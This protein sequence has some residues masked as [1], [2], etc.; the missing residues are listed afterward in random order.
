MSGDGTQPPLD[1]ATAASR[2]RQVAVLAEPKLK[3]RLPFYFPGKITGRTVYVNDTPRVYSLRD[4]D[5]N[6][7]RAYRIVASIGESG[8]FWGVQGLTWRTPWSGQL[9]V[10]ADNV[11]TRGKNPFSTANQ[12]DEGTVPYVRY[13]QDL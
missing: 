6:L 10:G 7:H 3:K 13:Q 9:S 5:G 1:A 11:V 8:E 2:A 4:E 12:D